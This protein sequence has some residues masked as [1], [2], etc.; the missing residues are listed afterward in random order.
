MKK[1]TC[2]TNM[3]MITCI[4]VRVRKGEENKNG[5]RGK[6]LEGICWGKYLNIDS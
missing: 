6:G 4:L 3:H 5:E 1:E 2:T